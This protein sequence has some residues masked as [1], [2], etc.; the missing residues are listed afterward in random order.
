MNMIETSFQDFWW[1]FASEK[2][3]FK[4]CLQG[5]TARKFAPKIKPVFHCCV[6]TC[7]RTSGLQVFG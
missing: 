3:V 5:V 6:Q 4:E 7:D 2:A 1:N